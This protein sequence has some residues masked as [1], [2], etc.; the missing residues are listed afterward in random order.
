MI[1]VTYDD[2]DLARALKKYAKKFDVSA[3]GMV[4]NLAYVSGYELA[5]VT[6]PYGI[7]LK[8]RKQ[9]ENAVNRDID[10]VYRTVGKTAT[11]LKRKHPKYAAVYLQL[12]KTDVSKADAYADKHLESY[13]DSGFDGGALHQ[14]QRRS[15]GRVDKRGYNSSAVSRRNRVDR[16][17]DNKQQLVG[18]AKGSWVQAIS[19]LSLK[20]KRVPKWLKDTPMKTGYNKVNQRRGW[21]ST[22]E[23]TS[24]IGY[25]SSVLRTSRIKSVLT[26]V[27]RNHT[28]YLKKV[29]LK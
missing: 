22:V 19:G 17:S 14:R 6:Q 4:K 11:A 18:L 27:S 13:V 26:R 7:G 23:I 1:R 25:M 20:K 29:T 12:L 15:K 16:Y 10:K 9:G 28:K 21:G 2:K 5:K 8:A 24:N 3:L